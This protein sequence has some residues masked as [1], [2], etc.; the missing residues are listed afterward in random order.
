MDV[1]PITLEI[2]TPNSV[3]HRRLAVTDCQKLT[4]DELHNLLYVVKPE[5]GFFP[6]TNE[7]RQTAIAMLALLASDPRRNPRP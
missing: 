6:V 3:A 2:R 4:N 7:T 5:M 1:H